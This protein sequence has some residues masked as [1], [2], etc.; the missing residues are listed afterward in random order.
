MF[1]YEYN[2]NSFLIYSPPKKRNRRMTCLPIKKRIMLDSS[3]IDRRTKSNESMSHLK[4]YTK[5]DLIECDIQYVKANECKQS[6]G[7]LY[8]M[9]MS[10]CCVV[11]DVYTVTAD[12][13]VAESSAAAAAKQKESPL[14]LSSSSASSKRSGRKRKSGGSAKSKAKARSKPKSKATDSSVSDTVTGTSTTTKSK[15]NPKA[16]PKAKTK[17]KLEAKTESDSAIASLMKMKESSLKLS[18]E[19]YENNKKIAEKSVYLSN[20]LKYESIGVNNSAIMAIDLNTSASSPSSSPV[21]ATAAKA[22][23]ANLA[24]QS[25]INDSFKKGK[26]VIIPNGSSF[27]FRT[28]VGSVNISKLCTAKMKIDGKYLQY[29]YG[30]K[31]D[32]MQSVM[33]SSSGKKKKRM[34]QK[35]SCIADAMSALCSSSS[36]SSS[37]SE[38]ESA[39]Y[40]CAKFEVPTIANLIGM[41]VYALVY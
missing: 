41:Y 33:G 40:Q 39:K 22:K 29:I 18:K 12:K 21:G 13:S 32:A 23:S 15:S 27:L 31:R 37:G 2:T 28:T 1:V 24:L 35:V 10:V 14:P 19:M 9:S 26:P 36:S 34:R 17:P 38:S 8:C 7:I 11:D 6:A 30:D 16:K 25:L 3:L 4:T 5:I 20:G